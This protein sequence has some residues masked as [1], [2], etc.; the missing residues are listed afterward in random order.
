MPGV[1]LVRGIR[2]LLSDEFVYT[3]ITVLGMETNCN[4]TADAMNVAVK[5][6]AESPCSENFVSLSTLV[7][8][9]TDM[10]LMRCIPDANNVR[11][12]GVLPKFMPRVSKD[13]DSAVIVQRLG[14]F[15]TKGLITRIILFSQ[16][17]R[18]ILGQQIFCIF[19]T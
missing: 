8:R 17:S 19:I 7:I 1:V 6:L 14:N 10:F 9:P 13:A 15:F 5:K 12:L 2:A 16:H 18:G 4:W 11:V 3:G